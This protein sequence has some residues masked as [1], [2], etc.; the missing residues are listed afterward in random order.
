MSRIEK[1]K[2]QNAV[3]VINDS[4][5]MA[6]ANAAHDLLP[7][8]DIV[9]LPL[10]YV[11]GVWTIHEDKD[12]KRPIGPTDPFVVDPLSFSE[13]VIRW[14]NKRPTHRF[15]GRRVDGFVAPPRHVL[16]EADKKDWPV[17][18]SGPV[19][20]WQVSQLVVL[21]DLA[22]GELVTWVSSSFGGKIALGEFLDR[23]TKE[24]KQNPGKCPVVVLDT[25]KRPTDYGETD[26]PRLKFTG[27]WEP[28]GP[29]ASPPGDPQRVLM[30]RHAMQSLKALEPPKAERKSDMD[31]AIPF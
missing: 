24:A 4:D 20:P 16:P 29:D 8:D 27:D 17:A 26:T 15:G 12:N 22:T 23:F 9:G 6:L 11:K 7:G 30:A 19:D 18:A 2:E 10:K 3:T 1:L 21:R 25:Y 13:R 14:E 28:F 31:D 5:L